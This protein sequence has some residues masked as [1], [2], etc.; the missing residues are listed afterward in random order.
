MELMTGRWGGYKATPAA[1][2][3]KTVIDIQFGTQ[4]PWRLGAFILVGSC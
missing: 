4:S 2:G 3:F 1:Q